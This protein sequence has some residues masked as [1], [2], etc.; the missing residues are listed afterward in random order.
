[1]HARLKSGK[2]I[3]LTGSCKKVL[4]MFGR[5]YFVEA[6]GLSIGW[7]GQLA[8]GR[9]GNSNKH[10]QEIFAPLCMICYKP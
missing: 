8:A 9:R 2:F 6:D 10:K 3:M 5:R 1:M 7:L 4:A